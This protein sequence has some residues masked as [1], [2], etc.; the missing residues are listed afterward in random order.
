MCNILVLLSLLICLLMCQSYKVNVMNP[1]KQYFR[2]KRSMTMKYVIPTTIRTQYIHKCFDIFSKVSISFA[3]SNLAQAADDDFLID[4][5]VKLPE[6]TDVCWMDVSID[7][8]VT[9][10]IEISLFGKQTPKTSANFKSL[11]NNENEIGYKGSS[12]FRVI[13]KFSIQ[14][15]NIGA[16]DNSPLSKL[17]KYG[18]SS[19]NSSFPPENYSI[20]HDYK[21][22]GVVSMMRDVMNKNQQDSRFFITLED[23]ASWADDKYVAFGIVTKGLDFIKN[24]IAVLPVVSPSNYPEKRVNII[25]SGTYNIN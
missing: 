3:I 19:F 20:K 12:F 5:N 23:K 17:G 22:A 2:L 21:N 6:I 13:S 15:G 18:I 11:C 10:R 25:A 9:E 14:G 7:G 1:S 24:N 8:K 16:P 4:L